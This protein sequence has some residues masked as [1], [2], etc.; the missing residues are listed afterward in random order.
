MDVVDFML[1]CFIS[2][3]I[4]FK[5]TL[6]R[7]INVMAVSSHIPYFGSR[8]NVMQFIDY[9]KVYLLC[10]KIFFWKIFV[11]YAFSVAK[12]ENFCEILESA[13]PGIWSEIQVTIEFKTCRKLPFH[14]ILNER[15]QKIDP[16]IFYRIFIVK[17]LFLDNI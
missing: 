7:Q 1:F 5:K 2:D 6:F 17:L 15:I 14:N 3:T 16:Q 12:Q 13:T 11:D 8:K 10:H 4:V 9:N